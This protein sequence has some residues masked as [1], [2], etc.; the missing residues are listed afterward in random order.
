MLLQGA[1]D[2]VSRSS[3]PRYF[4]VTLPQP[5]LNYRCTNILYISSKLVNMYHF[6][7][8][9]FRFGKRSEVSATDQR[10]SDIEAFTAS[11]LY[12]PRTSFRSLYSP[13]YLV[14]ILKYSTPITPNLID[15]E[16]SYTSFLHEII[17]WH[18]KK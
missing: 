17:A 16:N 9:N 13:R 8:D 18:P 12:S 2:S 1:D 15:L 5:C 4:I 14:P 7:H 3:R 11:R 6:G 10:Q